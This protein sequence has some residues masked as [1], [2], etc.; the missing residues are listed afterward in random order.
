MADKD[1]DDLDLTRYVSES[2]KHMEIERIMKAFKL[3][4]FGILEVPY[5]VPKA[6][7]LKIAYRKK[8]LKIHPDK[9]QHKDAQDAFQRL[10]KAESELNDKGRVLFL[11]ELVLEAKA[12]LVKEKGDKLEVTA[13]R[14]DDE[15][16]IDTVDPAK[17]PYV[18]TKQGQL[19][20]QK[21]LK[22]LLVENEL[23]R[24]RLMK[25]EL[26][27]EGEEARQKEEA[28]TERKRKQEEQKQWEDTRDQRVSSWR[29]FLNKDGKKKKRKTKE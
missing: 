29:S 7:E 19:A 22:N 11:M 3:D 24:R 27:K 16:M 5:E 10:K 26:E 23:K 20:I 8:S 6:K 13:V 9:V 17:F 2:E 15:T 14:F 1:L 12:E 25:R 4:P 28:I 21:R 18:A